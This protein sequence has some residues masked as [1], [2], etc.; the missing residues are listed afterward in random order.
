MVLM[1]SYLNSVKSSFYFSMNGL[2]ALISVIFSLNFFRLS[3]FDPL[4]HY[5]YITNDGYEWYTNGAYLIHRIFTTDLPQLTVLR[6]P[7]FVLINGLDY[8]FG[9]IGFILALSY[10]LS[11]FFTYFFS[12]E[13]IKYSINERHLHWSISLGVILG[14]TIAP[15]NYVKIYLLADSLAITLCLGSVYFMLGFIK[16]ER[17]YYYWLSIVLALAAGLTQSYT[18]IPYV[19]FAFYLYIFQCRKL[20]IFIGS[21]I[22][23]I[24]G[25]IIITFFWRHF[26]NHLMTPENL[27]LLKLSTANKD[28]YKIVWPLFL[29]PLFLPIIIGLPLLR[30]WISPFNTLIVPLILTSILLMILSFF[31]QWQESRFTFYVWPW[32]L[33]LT[34]QSLESSKKL[35]FI[36]VACLILSS[37]IVPNNYWQPSRNEISFST[38]N[39]IYQYFASDSMDRRLIQCEP[40]CLSNRWMADQSHHGTGK[41]LSIYLELLE[42]Q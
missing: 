3:H 2:M 21:I 33:I 42:S 29:W 17:R 9:S 25:F 15:I 36:C 18:F 35:L 27:S 7:T 10:G 37:F 19:I 4:N 24:I 5:P 1:L 39:W 14:V 40:G 13:I 34:L 6:P 20:K 41:T 38:N 31:Y 11:L 30:R 22:F 23:P 32:L 16:N 26:I 28:F 8:L 12:K